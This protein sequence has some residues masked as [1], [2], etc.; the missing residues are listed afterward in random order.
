MTKKSWNIFK[1]NL[2]VF[3]SLFNI[4]NSFAQFTNELTP[5]YYAYAQAR[6]TVI[7]QNQLLPCLD[8]TLTV[9]IHILK[10]SL[11]ET[12]IDTVDIY[13]AFDTLNSKFAP[14]CLRFKICSIDS[15]D[16]FQWDTLQVNNDDGLREEQQL[17]TNIHIDSTINVYFVAAFEDL[18][19]A[20]GFTSYPGGADNIFILK[21]NVD[22]M[23]IPHEF[24]HFFGLIHTFGDGVNI[25]FA[26]DSLCDSTCDF[27]CDTEADPSEDL[28]SAYAADGNCELAPMLQDDNDVYYMPP[29][30]NIMSY[31]GD[32]RCKFTKQQYRIMA[33]EY[34]HN[35]YYLW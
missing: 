23:S 8:K 16:N 25:G 13:T 14:I 5:A 9:S 3:I 12:N 34:L 6:N 15:V 17:V 2:I 11:G 29:T 26:N 33:Y 24:G 21:D 19:Q 1:F 7:P 4:T 20:T 18:P 30:D 27:L 31:Y 32:C 22:D 35:R 10:D 28:P